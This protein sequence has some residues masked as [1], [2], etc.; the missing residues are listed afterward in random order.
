MRIQRAQVTCHSI[1]WFRRL[2]FDEP[3]DKYPYHLMALL[4][5][6]IGLLSLCILGTLLKHWH[7]KIRLSPRK[8][9]TQQTAD[10]DLKEAKRSV[11]LFPQHAVTKTHK[12][13]LQIK[14]CIYFL[15]SFATNQ[16]TRRVVYIFIYIFPNWSRDFS[17]W[18]ES[19]TNDSF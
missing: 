1:D 18:D 17:L 7:K 15:P 8:T 3:L 14:M 2:S 5:H 6:G 4:G 19:K 13:S 10:D 12:P 9:T 16:K 11:S